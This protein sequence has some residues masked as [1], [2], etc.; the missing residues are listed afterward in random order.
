MAKNDKK[1][2]LEHYVHLVSKGHGYAGVFNYE[3]SND[4]RMVEKSTIEEWRRSI[5][6]EFGIKMNAP[7][8]NSNDPPDFFV[9]I[10][11]QRYAVE[12]VQ[13][14][15]QK[16]KERAAKGETPFQD[17]LFIE[18]QWSRERLISKLNDVILRK[19]EKYKKAGV[20]IDILLIHTT[21]PWLTSTEARAWLEGAKINTH[22]SIRAASLLFDYEPGRG[23]EHWAVMTVY[24]K[25]T[26]DSKD[27]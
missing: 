9:S 11:G 19:G 5:E 2:S 15:E 1:D 10:R 20:K 7:E 4:K 16:H 12:L 8:L 18:M 13:L 27:D 25:L 23:V 22:T 3:S 24:G 21:E 26:H 6:A 14:I 17:R